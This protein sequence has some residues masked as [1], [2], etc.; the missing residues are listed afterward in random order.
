MT[1]AIEV[2]GVDNFHGTKRYVEILQSKLTPS[3]L[4][5]FSEYPEEVMMDKPAH[6]REVVNAVTME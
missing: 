4:A 5:G 1:E 6:E 3:A 2:S